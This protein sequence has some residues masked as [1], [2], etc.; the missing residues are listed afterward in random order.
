MVF[1]QYRF[2]S[3]MARS[4]FVERLGALV[5]QRLAVF[6]SKHGALYGKVGDRG[7]DLRTPLTSR[8]S[9]IWVVGRLD[10]EAKSA[11]GRL[12]IVPE[13]LGSFSLV[14]IAAV[15]VGVQFLAAPGWLRIALPTFVAAASVLSVLVGRAEWRAIVGRLRKD[16]G[17]TL[18]GF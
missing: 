4:E 1:R 7:F 8:G 18:D 11:S 17:I 2:E 5:T 14:L 16:L 12:R 15:A 6:P 3:P 13:P 9:F 10:P